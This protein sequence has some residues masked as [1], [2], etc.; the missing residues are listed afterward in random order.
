MSSLLRN[1]TLETVF[2]PFPTKVTDRA[3]NADFRRKPQIHRPLSWK[4]KQVLKLGPSRRNDILEEISVQ[5]PSAKTSPFWKL[6]FCEPLKRVSDF[7]ENRQGPKGFPQKGYPRSGRSLQKSLRNYCIKCPK[8]FFMDTPFV[9]P[10]FGPAREKGSAPLPTLQSETWLVHAK[11]REPHLN[12]PVRMNFLPLALVLKG[13]ARKVHTNR[14]V[15]MWFANL[16]VNQPCFRLECRE[17]C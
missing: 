6:P 16:R 13:K 9:D 7:P 1:S 10:P 14:G 12:P 4:F 11:V 8:E 5:G 3:Q 17:R 15:Q 2:H